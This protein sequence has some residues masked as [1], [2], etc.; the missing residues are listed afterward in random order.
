MAYDWDHIF[1]E[2]VEEFEGLA[3]PVR[4]AREDRCLMI[5]FGSP[6]NMRF[7]IE[8]VPEDRRRWIAEVLSSQFVS[9]R[10]EAVDNTKRRARRALDELY[11]SIG[12]AGS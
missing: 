8:C 9:V 3:C 6:I 12:L 11:Y 1:G 7:N 4:I 10:D 5:E 2:T